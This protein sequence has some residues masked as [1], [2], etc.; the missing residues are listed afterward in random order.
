MTSSRDIQIAFDKLAYDLNLAGVGQ[1]LLDRLATLATVVRGYA[2]GPAGDIYAAD[3]ATT[4]AHADLADLDDGGP[5]LDTDQK[6]ARAAVL[7]TIGNSN[8]L[9]RLLAEET[10]PAP[11]PAIAPEPAVAPSALG[12]SQ[13]GLTLYQVSVGTYPVGRIFSAEVMGVN[14]LDALAVAP[15][16]LRARYPEITE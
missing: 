6:L 12:P 10:G 1:E 7:A 16:E 8:Q 2:A 5:A 13:D 3:P 11:E 14:P 9:A 4:A 15:R